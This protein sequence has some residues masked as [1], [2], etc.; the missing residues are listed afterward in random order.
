[1]PSLRPDTLGLGLKRFEE[2]QEKK[3]RL[4]AILPA[5]ARASHSILN[6]VPNEYAE[7]LEDN[8]EL[9]ELSVVMYSNFTIEQ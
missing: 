2:V 8:R 5:L 7:A 9:M 1:M 3:V 6:G 4:A